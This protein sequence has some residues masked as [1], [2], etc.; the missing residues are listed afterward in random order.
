MH[1]L[2]IRM[3]QD[4]FTQTYAKHAI[5]AKFV[6][7]ALID[8]HMYFSCRLSVLIEKEESKEHDDEKVKKRLDLDAF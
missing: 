8:L 1:A 7:R 6:R 4:A 2:Y 5:D 3:H